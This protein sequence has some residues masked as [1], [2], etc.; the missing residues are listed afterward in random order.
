MALVLSLLVLAAVCTIAG[1]EWLAGWSRRRLVV[2]FLLGLLSLEIVATALY[3]FQRLPDPSQIEAVARIYLHVVAENLRRLLWTPC[4]VIVVALAGT[5][6]L[7]FVVVRKRAAG[8]GLRWTSAFRLWV[9][10]FYDSLG[11]VPGPRCGPRQL[12]GKAAS[13]S[14]SSATTP[15]PSAVSS[16]WVKTARKTASASRSSSSSTT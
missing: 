10:A 14:E 9:I 12:C 8:Q 16:S 7:V 2:I 1:L 5:V 13:G 11:R 4:A 3:K 15:T 6:A